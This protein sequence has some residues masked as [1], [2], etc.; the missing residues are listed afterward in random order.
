ML[1]SSLR[2]TVVPIIKGLDRSATALNNRPSPQEEGT[3][4]PAFPWDLRT[5]I[6]VF[7]EGAPFRFLNLN[8]LL[9][10][11]G[12]P[13]D[14]TENWHGSDPGDAFDLQFC[15]E[16][17]DRHVTYKKYASVERDLVW[18][19]DALH[20][21]LGNRLL[22]EGGWPSCHI[23]YSQPEDDLDLTIHLES[24][25]GFQWWF[26]SPHL[27]CH[28][29]TFCDARLQWQW[30][31]ASGLLEGVALFDHGWGR[32]LLPLRVPLR[33]FRYE[34]MRLPE[35][36]SAVSLWTEGPG[37]LELKNVGL[38]RPD[39]QPIRFMK[40]YECRVLEW[41]VF[42]NY[43][44]RPCQVPTRWIGT[45]WGEPGRF[46]YEAV[47]RTEPRPILGEGFM[48]GFEFQGNWTGASGDRNQGTGY[49]EHLGWV[50]KKG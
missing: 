26:C 37:G 42:E 49:V 12:V 14:Q 33:V 1:P 34:V 29:T 5:L 22:L 35:G 48:Y 19:P 3:R 7:P 20:L 39:R 50:G 23:R 41:D 36:A 11:T 9:G 47:R 13:F 28:Y 30:K 25:P 32:N 45:Q 6:M 8:T 4:F 24:W 46:R 18:S 16:G 40:R 21:K 38:I 44:G 27:Y 15:L 31:G 10:L 17:K 2:R 43:A